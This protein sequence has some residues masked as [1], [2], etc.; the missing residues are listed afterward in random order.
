MKYVNYLVLLVLL[1]VAFISKDS[2][3]LSTNLLSLFAS[4]E[5]VE[6]L[7]IAS[8]LGYTKE[9]LVAVKGFDKNSK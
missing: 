1:I 6:K 9:L 8:D 2:M 5:S 4:K 7:S 3:H